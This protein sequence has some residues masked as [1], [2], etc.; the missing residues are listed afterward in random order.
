MI[1]RGLKCCVCFKK[2]PPNFVRIRGEMGRG[3]AALLG[4]FFLVHLFVYVYSAQYNPLNLRSNT[5]MNTP[6]LPI[7]LIVPDGPTKN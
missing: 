5:D 2:V 7:L 3:R 1:L 4:S 6:R